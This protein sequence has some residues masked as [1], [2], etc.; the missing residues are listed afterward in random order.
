MKPPLDLRL[1]QAFILLVE[2]GSFSETSRRVGRTQPAVS[3][4]M[5]RLEGATGA[6]LF[7]NVGR[8]LVLTPDG[9]LLLG[10]ARTILHLQEEVRARLSA[11]KLS[12]Q[13]ILGTPDLYAAYLLPSL[14]SE[15]RSAFPNIELEVRCALSSKLMAALQ[16]DEI[17]L[18]LVTGMPA[19]KEGELVAQEPLVWVSSDARSL[20]EENPVPLAMLP[21][22]NIFRDLALAGLDRVGRQWRLACVSESIGGL[23]A[24]VFGGIAVS[25]VAKSSVLPGMRQLGRS[26]SFPILPKVDLVLY[27]AGGRLNPA[28][29]AMAD[30]MIRHFARSS[31]APSSNVVRTQAGSGSHD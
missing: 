25:V 2:T 10:Y 26:E 15:F 3:L 1:L 17:D 13:V 14:L 7:T 20:H 31:L 30:L 16:R 4:Q 9:E 27:R 19:F 28:A 24:A 18:A 8:K 21:P 29:D 22:G 23:Q 11:Q 5:S 6:K 12:G